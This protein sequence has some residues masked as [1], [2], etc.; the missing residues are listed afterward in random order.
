VDYLPWKTR[1]DD[2]GTILERGDA[3]QAPEQEVEGDSSDEDGDAAVGSHV[4]LERRKGETTEEKKARKVP[5]Q[6][7]SASAA[8]VSSLDATVDSHAFAGWSNPAS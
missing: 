6:A 2:L 4:I 1:Q 7:L 3:A 8:R 5:R